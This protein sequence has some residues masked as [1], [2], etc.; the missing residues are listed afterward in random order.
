MNGQFSVDSL[1]QVIA[2]SGAWIEYTMFMWNS[3]VPTK[4]QFFAWQLL[5]GGVLMELELKHRGFQLAS[6]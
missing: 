5:H 6:K 4:I 2:G 1:F 3:C